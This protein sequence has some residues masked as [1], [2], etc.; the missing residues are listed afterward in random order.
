MSHRPGNRAALPRPLRS[1][2]GLSGVLQ[3]TS[4]ARPS[5]IQAFGD[6]PVQGSPPNDPFVL[7]IDDDVAVCLATENATAEP[8]AT[9]LGSIDGWM[10]DGHRII[11]LTRDTRNSFV[12]YRWDL[13]A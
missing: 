6:I 5:L 1:V 11:E 2:D 12:V 4:G 7:R 3:L 13:D 8:T 10:V 9:T